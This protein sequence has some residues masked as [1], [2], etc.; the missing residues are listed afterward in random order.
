MGAF[1]LHRISNLTKEECPMQEWDNE[2]HRDSEKPSSNQEDVSVIG[3]TVEVTGNLSGHGDLTVQGRVEGT[4]QFLKHGVT[5]GQGAVV[6]ADIE[7]KT[8]HI[9]GSYS[10]TVTCSDL[11]V[12]QPT[13]RAQGTLHAP[14]VELQDGCSFTGELDTELDK[15]QSDKSTDAEIKLQRP[16]PKAIKKEEAVPDLTKRVA[17]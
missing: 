6:E 4:I 3:P 1:T 14:R 9:Q 8:V 11:I 7:A 13:A 17:S 15:K 12:L 16:R 2:R 5:V 10:G